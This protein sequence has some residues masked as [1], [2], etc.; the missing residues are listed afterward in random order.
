MRTSFLA[1]WASFCQLKETAAL[2]RMLLKMKA[3]LMLE[4]L[5]GLNSHL[6]V[7]LDL[8]VSQVTPV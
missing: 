5:I 8:P 2:G 4:F 7:K 6:M 3:K 1:L